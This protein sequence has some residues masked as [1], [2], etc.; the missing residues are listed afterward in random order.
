MRPS[1]RGRRHEGP[2]PKGALPART[3]KVS[4]QTETRYAGADA[5][6]SAHRVGIYADGGFP[7]LASFVLPENGSERENLHAYESRDGYLGLKRVLTLDPKAVL[8]ELAASGMRGRGGAAFPTAE[9]W[10]MAVEADTAPILVVN[11]AE[12][13]PGSMKDR[14]LMARAP[15]AVLEGILIASHALGARSVKFYVND[16]FQDA[17]SSLREALK[18]ALTAGYLGPVAPVPC[19]I[20]LVPETHVYIAGEETA[21]IHVL[22][23]EPAVPWHKPPYPSQKGYLGQPTVVNNV[24]TL[25]QV[26][27]VFRI[28]AEAYRVAQ[29]M[30]FSVSGDV[31]RPGVY[32]M[33]LGTPLSQ[34]VERAGGIA[35]GR[36]FRGVLPGGYSTPML[37]AGAWNLALDYESVK[38]AGSG[39]GCSI[40]VLSDAQPP[41]RVAREVLTFFALESCGR[42]PTCVRGT[43]TLADSFAEWEREGSEAYG[44]ERRAA[45]VS[46]ANHLRHKGICSF[47]DT[48]AH[49]AATFA[50]GA[51]VAETSPSAGPPEPS[52]VSEA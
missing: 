31:A 8:N 11:G 48:A 34:L 45:L 39:L 5:I 13:E 42:C 46:T 1:R 22:M 18:E 33:P 51:S 41:V 43:R 50:E 19:E 49:F 32:E 44:V 6:R 23:G 10:R 24:D 37:G 2:S 25:A 7:S 30:L 52:R 26:A 21:L 38:Q 9:K 28:G 40:I 14:E 47:L 16:S 15:H 17:V 29:P 20:D 36:A 12:G 27:C 4:T 35:G 3:R